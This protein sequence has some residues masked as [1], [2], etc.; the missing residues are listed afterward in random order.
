MAGSRENLLHRS[1]F[2]P[3]DQE[4]ATSQLTEFHHKGQAQSIQR[5]GS[6]HTAVGIQQYKIQQYSIQRYGI[7][8]NSGK[9]IE[10]GKMKIEKAETGGDWRGIYGA[11]VLREKGI[12]GADLN[13]RDV[14]YRRKYF[15]SEK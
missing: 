4:S 15:F 11:P 13:N 6:Q 14:R 2:C 3:L 1:S 12:K 8:V 10:L 7:I 5:Y 9:T